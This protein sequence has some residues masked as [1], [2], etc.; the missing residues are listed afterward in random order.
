MA[1]KI[2]PYKVYKKTF[3]SSVRW[4]FSYS[5]EEESFVDRFIHIME[6]LSF[7]LEG[8]ESKAVMMKKQGLV[9]LANAE[10]LFI[11]CA[12]N[13]YKG[14]NALKPEL[15]SILTSLERLGVQELKSM[16]CVKENVFS[17]DK[18]KAKSKLTESLIAS[19]LFK[20]SFAVNPIFADS[21]D[22][23]QAVV[24]RSYSDTVSESVMKLLV[25]AGWTSELP[26]VAAADKLQEIDKVSYD[27]WS[28]VV[29]DGVKKIMES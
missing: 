27:A 14:F 23:I 18:E 2:S 8:K 9:V 13:V 26:M 4:L 16:N 24:T 6:G 22:G 12:V 25:T 15:L 11:N 19:I 7:G 1:L 17:I 28:F 5:A 10:L 29:S 3:L 20:E 21:R